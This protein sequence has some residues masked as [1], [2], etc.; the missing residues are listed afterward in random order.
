MWRKSPVGKPDV[1]HL[2]LSIILIGIF[3]V[4]CERSKERPPDASANGLLIVDLSGAA[5]DA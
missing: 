1:E 3:L 2:R 4:G 5:V